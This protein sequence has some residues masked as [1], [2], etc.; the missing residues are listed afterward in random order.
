M[1]EQ[2]L[3]TTWTIIGIIALLFFFIYLASILLPRGIS[4]ETLQY[5][6]LDM[7]KESR[8]Y[9]NIRYISY[10]ANITLTVLFLIFIIKKDLARTLYSQLES[11][12]GSHHLLNIFATALLLWLFLRLLTFPLSLYTGYIHEQSY[13]F[14]NQT[15]TAWLIDYLKGTLISG[16]MFALSITGLFFLFNAAPQTWWFLAS[17]FYVFGLIL[18]TMISPIVIDPLFFEFTPLE[19]QKLKES[20]IEMAALANIDVGEV[21]V[22][23]ASSKTTKVNAYFTGFG[24][25]KRIVLYDNLLN[26]FSKEEIELVIAHEIGHWEHNHIVK[27]ISLAGFGTLLVMYLIYLTAHLL[28]YRVSQ[29]EFLPVILLMLFVLIFVT[30]PFQNSISRQFEHQADRRALELTGSN[31]HWISLKKELGIQNL[32]DVDPHPYIAWFSFSHPPL[33]ERIKQAD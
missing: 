7:I 6:S 24:Q 10:L 28:N 8:T 22:V 33:V 16:P 14:S 15:L 20:I 23:N 25:T 21:L 11:L 32:A 9:H 5:F 2:F 31:E 19:D 17:I 29:P 18:M 3:K 4:Q 30:T 1:L 13:G 12:L 27:G 26:N